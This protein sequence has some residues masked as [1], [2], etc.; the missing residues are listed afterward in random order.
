MEP[1]FRLLFEQSPALVLVLAPDAPKYTAIAATAAYWKA[2]LTSAANIGRG[3]FEIFPDNPDDPTANGTGNLR[4]S[5]D[6]VM[7]TRASDTM[8]VQKYDVRGADDTFEV[9]YWSPKNQPVLSASGEVLFIVHRVEDV[10]DLVRASEQG[11]QLRMRTHAMERNVIERSREL[12]TALAE[13]RSAN[14][15]LAELDRTKTEFF[16]NVSHEFRTP[17][18][19][20]LGVGSPGTELEFAL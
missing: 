1:D 18:T 16:S 7:A 9:K 4:A 20:M 15:K 19:L 6:R 13:L 14:V 17:L 11:D 10:T 12:E 5:L 3:L 2:T 8:P